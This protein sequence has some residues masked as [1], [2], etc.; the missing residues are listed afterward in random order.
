MKVVL[1]IVKIINSGHEKVKRKPQAQLLPW[2]NINHQLYVRNYT[3]VSKDM[4][5]A[6]RVTL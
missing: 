3:M 1:P 5:P 4:V 6:V 2:A